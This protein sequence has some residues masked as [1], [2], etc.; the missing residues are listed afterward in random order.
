M[1]LNLESSTIQEA[2]RVVMKIAPPVQGTVTI[3]SDG[4]K[5]FMHSVS[6]VNRCTYKLPGK[7]EGKPTVF[8][9]G[10]ESLMAAT[11]NRKEIELSYDK[12]MLKIKSGNYRVDLA[13][14]DALQLDYESEK[15][16]KTIKLDA[17][18]ASWLK[19]AVA[20]VA[21]KPTAILSAFMPV[22]IK[23]TSKGTFI[24]CYDT[25]HM[26]FLSTKEIKGDMDVTLPLDTLTSI[27][28]TFNNAAFQMEMSQANLY[29]TNV[30]VSAVLAMPEP[31]ENAITGDDVRGK[32]KEAS[33]MN[34]KEIELV[35]RDV[36]EFL[37]NA[38][39]V[40]TKERGEIKLLAE[41]GKLKLSVVTVNGSAKTS[42]KAATNKAMKINIDFEYFEE[43]V[44][45]CDDT[46][47]LKV[48]GKDFVMFKQ[49]KATVL[50]ALNQDS[51]S[52]S[53]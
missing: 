21:L 47:L 32:A 11:R 19:Q 43:A 10:V 3:E 30:L 16:T 28:D 37:D 46:V 31:E 26:A 2:L 29:V 41:K 49:K 45:K 8:A 50:V 22:S 23:M 34:G 42:L 24:A 13:T 15:K 27:L 39:A 44:R 38:K 53:E 9:I 12:M 20:N 40:T 36:V 1:I 18:Q 5:A 25:Q 17:E 14:S 52:A 6:D 7:V 51:A 35:K 4:K 33:D 48:V